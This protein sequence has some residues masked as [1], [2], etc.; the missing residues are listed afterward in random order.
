MKKLRAFI[1][2]SAIVW[3]TSLSGITYLMAQQSP[4]NDSLKTR[5]LIITSD[6]EES[7]VYVNDSLVGVTPVDII[8]IMKTP[9]KLKLIDSANNKWNIS[10]AGEN[11]V[12]NSI[13]ALIAKN[14]GLLNII[15]H[16][17]GAS[18]L[19]NDSLIGI[20]PIQF[21]KVPL[22]VI[23]IDINKEGYQTWTMGYVL[24]KE[25]NRVITCTAELKSNYSTMFFNSLGEGAK[26]TMSGLEREFQ[27]GDSLTMLAG[28]HSVSVH[29]PGRINNA[30]L[31]FAL[32]PNQN[33]KLSLRKNVYH[34][35]LVLYSILLPGSGQF[36][37][38]AKAKGL[39]I[40]TGIFALGSAAYFF[41]DDYARKVDNYNSARIDYLAANDE[42]TAIAAKD[43]INK[44]K[45]E[46]DRSLQKKRLFTALFVGAYLY[47]IL[48]V[49]VFHSL[50]EELEL[51]ALD[52]GFMY[53]PL[54]NEVKSF[55]RTDL[56][57]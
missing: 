8:G 54:R 56:P 14:Y 1:F 42:I 51:D 6:P 16:P 40:F 32:L 33:Y 47:N 50:K 45:N 3:W 52:I 39:G 24:R 36:A 2:Y 55:V 4:K 48:D 21:V 15:S 5:N 25:Y 18:V 13:H 11:L 57:W 27:E 43:V 20:T 22:G 41:S 44:L 7:R 28:T 35:E 10:I 23:K 30:E 34:P 46:A 31:H 19:V 53:D 17:S 37:D 9:F 38:G 49:V 26:V 12:E 29:L